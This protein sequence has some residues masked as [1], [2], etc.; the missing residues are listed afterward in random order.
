MD[1][2]WGQ[3]VVPLKPAAGM[4]IA[5]ASQPNNFSYDGGKGN[6]SPFTRPLLNNLT[7]QGMEL[8]D[9]FA[10]VRDEMDRS[11]ANHQLPQALDYMLNQ[12][13]FFLQMRS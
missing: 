12:F 6:N 5:F 1:G 8:R 13:I 4:Y 9:L 3:D 10:R 2:D 11:A 7:V